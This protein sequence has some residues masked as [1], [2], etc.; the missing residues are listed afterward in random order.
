MIIII[1]IKN[2]IAIFTIIIIIIIII[3]IIIMTHLDS[4]VLRS[5]R[6]CNTSILF[7]LGKVLT[8]SWDSN[9]SIGVV[10][11]KKLLSIY[12][13]VTYVFID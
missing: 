3:V 1:I 8:N 11:K 4:C 7:T 9:F 6:V 5:S 2:I 13:R 10:D 12:H